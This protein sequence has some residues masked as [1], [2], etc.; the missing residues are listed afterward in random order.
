MKRARITYCDRLK[1]IDKLDQKSEKVFLT[2]KC[3]KQNRGP[4]PTRGC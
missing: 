4:V 1:I 3:R 2:E